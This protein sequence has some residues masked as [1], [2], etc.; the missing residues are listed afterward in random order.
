MWQESRVEVHGS[1]VAE[2]IAL[3]TRAVALGLLLPWLG[4]L[5]VAAGILYGIVRLARTRRS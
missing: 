3:R 5:A 2:L 4:V 1:S